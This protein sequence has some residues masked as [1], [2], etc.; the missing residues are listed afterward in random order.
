MKSSKVLILLLAL[1]LLL[2]PGAL[3]DDD[4]DDDDETIMG[5]DAE[6]LGE[7]AQILMIGT[8]SIALWRPSFK[9]LRKN[10]PDLFGKEPRPF[11]RKLGVFNRYYMKI[12]NWIGLATVVI[13]TA[14][15]YVLEWH[16][17]LWVAM[18]ALWALVFSGSLMQWKWPPK[19]FRKGAR[20]LHMQRSLTIIAIALLLIGHGIVD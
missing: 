3:A 6:D 7:V 17:T 20:L 4:D 11:K 12:H 10:G 19:E 9:W 2:A 15:G 8:C 5:T 1:M 16:W 13:G 14:H 18:G